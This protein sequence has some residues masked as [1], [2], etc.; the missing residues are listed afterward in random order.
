MPGVPIKITMKIERPPDVSQR[1]WREFASEAH[2]EMGQYW[3]RQYL[4]RHFEPGARERHGYQARTARYAIKKNKLYQ[5]GIS[6]AASN[7]DLVF[8]GHMRQLLTTHATIRAYPT[9]A[10]WR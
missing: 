4:P 1:K 2:A 3:H 7:Q 10:R 6:R 8:S 5:R 9:R